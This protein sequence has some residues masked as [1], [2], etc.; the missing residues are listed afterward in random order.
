MKYFV[1]YYWRMKENPTWTGIN[2]DVI[3]LDD[4][5]SQIN[6]QIDLDK[7]EKILSDKSNDRFYCKIIN[8]QPLPIK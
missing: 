6:D 7:I 2:N 1:S 4:E 8:I 5:D 3:T